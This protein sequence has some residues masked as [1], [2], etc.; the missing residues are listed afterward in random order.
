MRCP[1]I[2]T[3]LLLLLVSS[4]LA[5]PQATT[6]VTTT[7]AAAAAPTSTTSAAAA[8]TPDNASQAAVTTGAVTTDPDCVNACF[9]TAS[10]AAGCDGPANAVCTCSN[11]FLQAFLQCAA[12]NC[13]PVD[14]A[15]GRQQ[16]SSV[17]ASSHSAGDVSL[18]F[19]ATTVA[20][21]SLVPP[22]ATTASDAAAAAVTPDDSG[23]RTVL[24]VP[25]SPFGQAAPTD[26]GLNPTDQ[27]DGS[28]N[29]AVSLGA[30]RSV[31]VVVAVAMLA[32]V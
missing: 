19:T 21:A 23:P 30:M 18:T 27:T 11:A 1:L 10:S 13:T 2:L 17:C 7:S 20:A 22:P 31:F 29:G 3:S 4:S 26:D 32:V 28:S 24:S 6:S 12:L 5:A 25:A 9:D 8:K 14:S 16:L 15:A